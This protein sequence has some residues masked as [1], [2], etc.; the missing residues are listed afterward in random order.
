MATDKRNRVF[1]VVLTQRRSDRREDERWKRDRERERESWAR[2]DAR[3]TFEQRRDCYV[4]F[5][6]RLRE[7]AVATHNAAY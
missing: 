1:G 2:E 7:A 4:D 3:R 6:Q 5:L